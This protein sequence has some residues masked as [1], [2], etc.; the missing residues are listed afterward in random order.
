MVFYR[1][2]AVPLVALVAVAGAFITLVQK[3]Q[4]QKYDLYTTIYIDAV[5]TAIFIFLYTV[6]QRGF[7]SIQQNIME[8]LPTDIVLFILSGL[9]VAISVI[10]GKQLLLHNEMS[11]LGIMEMGIGVLVTVG[12]AMVFLGETIS[13]TQIVGL[14]TILLGV[15]IVNL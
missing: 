10:I 14:L 9:A 5:I 7:K 6:H 1:A 15:Y 11:Y 4:L 12:V 3:Y 2:Y 8:M 13:L